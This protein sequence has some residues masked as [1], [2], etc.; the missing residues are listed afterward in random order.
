MKKIVLILL[1]CFAASLTMQAQSTKVLLKTTMGDMTLMLYDDTP[2]HK[3][4]FIELVNKKFYDG[5]LFHRVMANFMIQTGDPASKDAK[6]GARLG[7]GGPGYTTIAEMRPNYYH[8]KG[9]LAAARQG[10]KVNPRRESSG[11]QFYIVQGKKWTGAQLDQM[12][13]RGRV[14]FTD[15]QRK[16]YME[17]GGYAPLDYQYTVFGEVIKGL[18]IIDAIAKVTCDAQNRPLEDVKIISAR[19]VK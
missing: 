9:A 19:I 12:E 13:N 16:Q 17:I 3:D 1:V 2:A 10:D 11:S 7:S 14:K 8:K 4:N 18:E 6:K 5:L 15:E